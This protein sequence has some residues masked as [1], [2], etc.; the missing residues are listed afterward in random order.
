[1]SLRKAAKY[2]DEHNDIILLF[3]NMEAFIIVD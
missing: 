2:I 1:M 3:N